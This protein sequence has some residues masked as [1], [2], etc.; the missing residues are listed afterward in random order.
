MGNVGKILKYIALFYANILD[1]SSLIFMLV[2]LIPSTRHLRHDYA[3]SIVQI[4]LRA[5]ITWKGIED[6]CDGQDE[7]PL[8][9][10]GEEDFE[11]EQKLGVV[12]A[13]I[14]DI[15]RMQHQSEILWNFHYHTE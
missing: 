9:E 15:E 14:E 2:C 8:H 10:S 5:P 13:A 12:G 3:N 7:H 11:G 1:S 4:N 6:R